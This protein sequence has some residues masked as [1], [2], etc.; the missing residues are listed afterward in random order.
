MEF[1]K[2]SKHKIYVSFVSSKIYMA[3]DY[4][5]DLFE[6]E[7]FKTL[8]DYKVAMEYVKTL[9]LCIG[10]VEELKLDQKLWSKV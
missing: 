1:K 5:K 2:K 7:V 8:L 9:H 3:I 4:G 10:I 6:P